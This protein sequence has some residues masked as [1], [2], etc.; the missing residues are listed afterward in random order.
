MLP[1]LELPRVLAPDLSSGRYYTLALGDVH[2]KLA[3]LRTE[4]S[5][6]LLLVAASAVCAAIGQFTRLLSALAA[7]AV[8]Q[9]ASPES[10]PNS[11]SPVRA[12][13]VA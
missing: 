7:V 5:K 10:N 11:P 1:E 4:I 12:I 2:R 13:G 8:S 9:A 6:L 3:S